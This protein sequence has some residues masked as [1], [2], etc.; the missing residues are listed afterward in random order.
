MYL[1]KKN[2]TQNLTSIS[3]LLLSNFL[4]TPTEV[5]V[6]GPVRLFQKLAK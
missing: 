5:Q 4:P 2:N 3:L 6:L 1:S